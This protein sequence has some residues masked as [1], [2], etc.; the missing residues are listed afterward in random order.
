M[1]CSSTDPAILQI[2][3]SMNGDSWIS[4]HWDA[5]GNCTKM[6]VENSSNMRP[7]TP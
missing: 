6:T 5:Q 7:K 4:F 2:A 3:Q 1:S